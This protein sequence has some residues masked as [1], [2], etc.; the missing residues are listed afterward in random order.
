MMRRD[1]KLASLY[2]CLFF[3]FLFKKENKKWCFVALGLAQ[4]AHIPYSKVLK[5]MGPQKN[6]PTQ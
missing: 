5:G 4:M 3:I 6:R 2:A 1:P